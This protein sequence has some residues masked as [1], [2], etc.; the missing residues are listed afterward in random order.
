MVSGLT[1]NVKA[2]ATATLARAGIASTAATAVCITGI[3]TATNR[4]SATARGTERRLRRHNEE[5]VKCDA[6]GRSRRFWWT[7]SRVGMCRLS[8]SKRLAFGGA[9]SIV[10][11]QPLLLPLPV[12]LLDGLTL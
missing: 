4:P 5:W 11:E 10:P 9:S 7:V 8:H 6:N 3:I 1:T 2:A 12:T